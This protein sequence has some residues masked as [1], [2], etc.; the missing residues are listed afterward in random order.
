MPAK[1]IADIPSR[2]ERRGG[3]GSFEAKTQRGGT[4]A[5]FSGEVVVQ[6]RV[7]GALGQR[8]PERIEKAFLLKGRAGGSA[9][10]QLV[11]QF[12][13][14]RRLFTP[15]HI[16]LHFTRYAR[17]HTEILTVPD[18]GT[19]IVGDAVL[20]KAPDL[21]TSSAYVEIKAADRFHTQI[22]R[23]NEMWLTGFTHLKIIGWG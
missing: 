6:L 20:L 15:G 16:G 5:T 4:R 2:K 19:N 9:D 1:A 23:P 10:Q 7:Q 3:F 21:I 17:P 11:E 8:L 22:T 18:R 13:R 14:H 12:V